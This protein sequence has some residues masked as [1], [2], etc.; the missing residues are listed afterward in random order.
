MESNFQGNTLEQIKKLGFLLLVFLPALSQAG[1]LD[2]TFIDPTDG[3]LDMSN[4]L[5][6]KQGFLPVPVIIT[7]PAIGYGGGLAM[8]YFHDKVGSQK[9]SPPSVSALVG[10]ATE[11]GT[12][13]AGGGHLGI[14]ADDTIRYTGG[15]GKGV[16]KM[17]YYGLP[18]LGGG[19][20]KYGVYFETEATFFMQELQ[21][22]LWDSNF[23]AGV[24]YTFIDTQNKF[25]LSAD[26]LPPNLPE[27]SF[28]SRS[29]ALNVMLNYD[30][31]DNLFT[32]SKGIAGEIKVMDFNENWGGDDNYKKYRA[33]ILSY[34]TLS[35]TLILG[36]RGDVKA[37]EGDAPFYAY[38]FID[39]RGVK[40]M[41]FKEIKLCLAKLNCAGHSHAVG[42]WLA[43]VVQVKPLMTV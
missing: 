37:L 33:S 38:P 40:A 20:R 27:V 7:E 42:R 19:E 11:N 16:V 18:S 32:P 12:W 17:E 22:R 43:L 35:D 4:W 31:R 34:T 26:N 24:G 36:L 9:G 6:E 15:L 2:D 3:Q 28:D 30:S 25:R 29:A 39:M 41:Q 5:L 21:F 14:W 13:F 8:V 1:W 23:F 10:A